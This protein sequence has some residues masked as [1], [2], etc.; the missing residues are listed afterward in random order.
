[1]VGSQVLKGRMGL[2]PSACL[3]LLFVPGLEP[4]GVKQVGQR[5]EMKHLGSG[6]HGGYEQRAKL[7]G[8]PVVKQ[9]QKEA[10]SPPNKEQPWLPRDPLTSGVIGSIAGLCTYGL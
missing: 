8:S 7:V 6:A 2:T 3:L 5:Q 10:P 9:H 1:M 4:T